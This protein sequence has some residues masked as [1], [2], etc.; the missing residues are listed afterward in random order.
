MNIVDEL[1]SVIEI[2]IDIKEDVL[3]QKLF[4]MVIIPLLV[5]VTDLIPTD[6]DNLWVEANKEDI[7]AKFLVLL[8]AGVS[9]AEKKVEDALD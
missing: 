4:D 6:I 2:K 5:K 8:A 3:G 9:H 1:K 7:K